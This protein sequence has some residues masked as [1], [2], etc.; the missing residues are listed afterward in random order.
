MKAG[1][2]MTTGAA[3]V[4]PDASLADA[5]R[6]LIEH[7]ISGLP[8]VDAV[9]RLVGILTEQDFLRQE[10]GARPRWLDVLLR[11]DEKHA[12]LHQ[13]RSRR[14]A[15]VMSRQPISVGVETPV[16]HL[17]DL[18]EHHGI[19]RLPVVQDGSVVGIVSRSNLLEAMV[20]E[21]NRP[22]AGQR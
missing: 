21:A 2:V 16:D 6:I 15:D 11:E 1:D 18:M 5:A 17:L 14:V 19:K 13:L 7:R 10:D 12:T 9:G 3:T 20:R 4:R 22:P 8:V